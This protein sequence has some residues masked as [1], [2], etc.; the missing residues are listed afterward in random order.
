M[1]STTSKTE[2]SHP[3]RSGFLAATIL[4]L[5]GSSQGVPIDLTD[6]TPTVTGSTSIRIDGIATLGSSYWADFKWNDRTNKFDVT[7]YGEEDSFPPDGFVLVEAGTFVMGS[8]DTELGRH[9]DEIQHEVTLTRDFY[10][11]EMEVTQ[12]QWVAVMR[13]NP[14]DFAG[15]DDCPVETVSFLDAVDYCNARSALEGLAPAYEVDSTSVSWNSSTNGY[16]LPTESEWE[17]AC[18]GGTTTAFYSGPVTSTTC[19]DPNLDDIAWYCGNND[20][21]GTKECGQKAP[22][23]W[24]LYDMSGNVWEWCWDRFGPYPAGPV[25]DPIGPEVGSRRTRRGGSWYYEAFY[26]RS[27][28]RL[29][30][31]PSDANRYIGFRVALSSR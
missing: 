2:L 23:P 12:A 15:C 27:A 20:T 1:A 6:A 18:R 14:S 5:A 28:D 9:G 24:G 4:M 21:W 3:V 7:A 25:I 8:P 29:A 11:S 31:L 13:S 30:S 16:R 26:C 10:L 17:Y 22:N 19:D